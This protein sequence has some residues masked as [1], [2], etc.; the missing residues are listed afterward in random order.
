MGLKKGLV[1]NN[2]F[3]KKYSY[4]FSRL[5]ETGLQRKEIRKRFSESVLVA[6]SASHETFLV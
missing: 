6:E 3:G 2:K 5:C 4:A 1:L